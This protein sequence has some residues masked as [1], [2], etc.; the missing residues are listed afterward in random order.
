MRAVLL[1]CALLLSGAPIPRAAEA[2]TPP[3]ASQGPKVSDDAPQAIPVA[4]V[5]RR[6]DEAGTFLRLLDEQLPPSPQ[7]KRIDQ[8]LPALS[9][10]LADRFQQTRQTLES[11]HGLGTLDSLVDSWRSSRSGLATWMSTVTERADWLEQQRAELDKLTA[12]WARTRAEVRTAKAPPELSERITDVI[13]ALTGA[14]A[15]VEA[16]SAATLVLQDRVARE[17]DRVDRALA[18]IGQARR[19]AAGGL[20]VRDSPP[21][22]SLRI[23]PPDQRAPFGAALETLVAVMSRFVTDYAERIALH[24][25]LLATLV[26]LLWW[27]RGHALDLPL[28]EAAPAP[29]IAFDHPV[30]AA[31][32][33]GMLAAFWI[34][35]EEPRTAR[36]I[37]EIGVFPPMVL[38]L[39][40][41]VTSPM[42]P[43]LYAM[44]AFFPVDILRDVLVQRPLLERAIFLLEMLAA[45]ALLGWFIRT[46]RV[47]DLIAAS[48]GLPPARI[49]KTLFKLALVGVVLALTA[50]I[51]GNVSLARL[52]GSGVLSSGYLAM[53]LVAGRRLAEGLVTFALRARP[54][55][56]L[57][58]VERHGARLERRTQRLLRVTSIIVWTIG[59]LDYFGALMPAVDLAR[60]VLAAELGF[61]ELSLS[62]GDV[63]AFALTVYLASLVSR[64]AQ[65]VL[66]EDVLPRLNLRPGLPYALLSLVKYAIIS[67]G[68]VLALLALGVNL[69][70]VTV[71]GGALGIGV[72]FGLQNIVNNFV[73]GLI[74][75]FERPVRVGDA[76]QIGDV[77]G[78]VRRIGIRATTVRAWEGAEVIVPNSQLVAERVMNWTPTEYRR[79]LDMP[80]NVAYGSAPDQVLKVLTEVAQSH[81]DVIASPAPVALFLGFGDSA[82][83]F[84][85]RAWTTRLDRHPMVR[86]E[87]G[88]AVYAALQEAGFSIPFPQQEIRIHPRAL[89]PPD[90]SGRQNP[91]GPS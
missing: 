44:A 81:A 3:P 4:E 80:V 57:H 31:L 91:P 65:F 54:L 17:M 78:E 14:G 18:Q 75:L 28:P 66:A 64:L 74:L 2:Q 82:L 38:I 85:L 45:A 52:I 39:R 32:V 50:D 19:R 11:R 59:T 35:A 10:R 8:E 22:W 43:A 71:L 5:A 73:S 20:L 9:Q 7:I 41:L 6:A 25:A 72:G 16:E 69:N 76:V 60:Q 53:V 56:G 58:M 67:I 1:A 84:E 21:I 12:V 86:S 42:R 36:L 87:L 33:L 55:V 13:T 88:V 62:L 27:I 79:R 77:Q 89:P 40:R 51:I 30:A 48:G 15:R 70:R 68:F 63:L 37:V 26:A 61:G 90:S 47:N 34:Y 23:P 29:T 46:G 49:R 24:L 83:R